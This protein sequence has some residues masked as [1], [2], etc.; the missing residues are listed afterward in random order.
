MFSN[1]T[2]AMVGIARDVSGRRTV[3]FD[4]L[5]F[6]SVVPRPGVRRSSPARLAFRHASAVEAAHRGDLLPA[7]P[8]S[9]RRVD[10]GLSTACPRHSWTC[11]GGPC[12]KARRRAA[13]SCTAAST[14]SSGP[15]LLNLFA[16]MSSFKFDETRSVWS[17]VQRI[18]RIRPDRIFVD[19]DVDL[20]DR[21]KSALATHRFSDRDGDQLPRRRRRAAHAAPG[22]R[23]RRLVQDHRSVRQP[24]AEFLL[25]PDRRRWHSRWTPIST[26]PLASAHAF[27]VLSHWI[28]D[29]DTD[30]YDIHQI[31]AF[32]QDVP[33]FYQLA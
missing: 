12:S 8:R 11:C 9:R 4:D 24:A 29:G 19:V 13:P 5:A 3:R 7:S 31:L 17:S 21:V 1:A 2:G 15:G 30:P 16:K 33:L 14:R 22:L 10:S 23:P 18:Y 6:G 25:E 20:R 32:R 27:Q 26:T 28:T